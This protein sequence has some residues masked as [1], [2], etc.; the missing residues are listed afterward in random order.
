MGAILQGREEDPALRFPSCTAPR[1]RKR[2]YP[3]KPHT[4]STVD[5]LCRLRGPKKLEEDPQSCSNEDL[6]HPLTLLFFFLS[7]LSLSPHPPSM[8][9]AAAAPGQ[10]VRNGFGSLWGKV[11]ALRV[12]TLS[13]GVW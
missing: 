2:V 12:C 13:F 11:L 1:K 3:S 10:R 7:S 6:V 8:A 9:A 5:H 4:E